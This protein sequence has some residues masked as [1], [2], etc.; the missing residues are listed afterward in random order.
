MA[1]D[2]FVGALIAVVIVAGIWCFR[3]EFGKSSRKDK[4]E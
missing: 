4:E 3:L 1:Q 2:I